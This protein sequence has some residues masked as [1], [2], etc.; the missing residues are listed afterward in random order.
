MRAAGRP[1]A[2]ARYEITPRGEFSLAAANAHFGGWLDA[3]DQSGS[4][5]VVMA[6]PVEGWEASAAVLLSQAADGTVTGDISIAQGRAI[7]RRI[8]ERLGTHIDT[9]HGVAHASPASAR[10]SRRES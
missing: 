5:A 7:R 4:P 6:F 2:A 1:A 9:P 8:A 10:S 3:G